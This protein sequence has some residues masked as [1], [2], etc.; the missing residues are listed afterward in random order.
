MTPMPSRDDF[1][2]LA[3]FLGYCGIRRVLRED[4]VGRCEVEITPDLCNGAR[5]AH[6]G[7]LMT[8]LDSVMAGAAR[9][10]LDDDQGMMTIDMQTQFLAPG[11]GRL[12]GE[13]R[14][15]RAG[16]SLIFWV[17]D[18]RDEDGGLVARATGVFRP[19][20]PPGF[21]KRP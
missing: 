10:T 18:V 15:V 1:G 7:L 16:Q 9:S 11:R 19:R 8:L 17:G 20:R 13:G 4:G 12:L 14:V 3:P 21:V 5:A 2:P 6:G